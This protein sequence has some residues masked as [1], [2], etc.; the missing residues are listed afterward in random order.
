MNGGGDLNEQAVSNLQ[1][2]INEN[3]V[4]VDET[5]DSTNMILKRQNG[6]VALML[7]SLI[8]FASSEGVES[9]RFKHSPEKDAAIAFGALSFIVSVSM[10]C[11][12]LHSSGRQVLLL[13]GVEGGLLCFLSIWWVFGISIITRVGGVAY[14][15]LNIY[16]ASWASF[17]ISLYL[18]NSCA[19]SHG[20]ISAKELT[21][22][23]QTL[24][25]W[26][27][28]LFISLIEFGS[29]LDSY[30]WFR[31][32]AKANVVWAITAGLVSFV[33]SVLFTLAHYRLACGI[34]TISS[35]NSETNTNSTVEGTA[36]V[37]LIVWWVIAVGLTTG[38][39]GIASTISG[40]SHDQPG[41]NLYVAIWAG[42]F[43]SCWICWTWKRIKSLQFAA[44]QSDNFSGDRVYDEN[45]NGDI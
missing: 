7:A 45:D 27:A 10:Y 14:E 42:F 37:L 19:S 29:A 13:K 32:S 9:P 23:S 15:A 17:L 40:T 38:E 35:S 11:L 1:I 8:S 5:S 3:I 16:F 4:D 25:V 36:S 44:Q 39:E 41:S 22:L 24:P 34:I 21:H 31:D 33:V 43:S 12:H 20:Y 30:R 26:Y 18:L 28:L 6:Y 2:H